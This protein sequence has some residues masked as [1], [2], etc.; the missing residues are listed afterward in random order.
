MTKKKLE[1]LF[2]LAEELYWEE[3]KK[4]GM[5]TPMPYVWAKNEERGFFLAFSAFGVD[6]EIMEKKLKEI[7]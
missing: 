5:T 2:E 4:S 1:K 7:I 3:Q 6:S